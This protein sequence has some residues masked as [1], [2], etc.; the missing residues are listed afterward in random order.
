MTEGCK[1]V[2]AGERQPVHTTRFR[3]I[4]ALSLGMCM[5]L[6]ACSPDRDAAVASIDIVAY[7]LLEFDRAGISK[8]P[9]SSV[10]AQLSHATRVR[11]VQQTDRIPLREGLSYGIAFRV[12]GRPA[13][14]VVPVKVVLRGSSP[15]V[16]K[17]TREVV[18]HN[19]TV[20]DVKL[21]DLRHIGGRI[22]G[23]EENHCAE[24]PGP[25]TETFEFYFEGRKLAEKSFHL[26][27]EDSRTE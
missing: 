5:G 9:T 18:Y 24:V 27:L 25:G 26:V 7:G 13:G 15:C 23:G 4:A 20:L 22:T 14:A 17:R 6:A 19:D 21:G 16:L 1:R 12:R 3:T 10:G 8:D 2:N 11:V